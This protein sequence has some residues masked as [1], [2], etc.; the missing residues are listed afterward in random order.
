MKNPVLILSGATLLLSPVAAWEWHQIGELREENSALAVKARKVAAAAKMMAPEELPSQKTADRK[1]SPADVE[2][3]ASSRPGP[4]RTPEEKARFEKMREVQRAQRIES[5]L[6][7]LTTKLNLTPD[8]KEA[9]QAALEKGSKDR[10]AIREAAF[11]SADGKR[12]GPEQ[13]AASEKT[14]EDAILAT[15]TPDQLGA[16]DEYKQA[17]KQTRVETR[18]SQQLNELQSSLALTPGQRDAAFQLFAEQAQNSAIGSSAAP[19]ADPAK[20]W[21]AQHQLT[22]QAMEKILTP[23]QYE[24]Y[25]KQDAQRTELFGKRGP[26]GA[27]TRGPGP[28]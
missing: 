3:T 14:Q 20:A 12:P 23:E 25:Q 13:F 6:L 21:E 8:Q 19:D 1:A 10:D 7:A 9:V 4:E 5:R 16:Y 18:A 17:E 27:P 11:N 2:K 15:L 26:G 28:F 24:L 22:L